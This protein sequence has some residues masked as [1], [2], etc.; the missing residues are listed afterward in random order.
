MSYPPSQEPRLYDS[1][2]P[3]SEAPMPVLG[4]RYADVPLTW[5]DAPP[6]VRSV[7]LLAVLAVI[8]SAF[9]LL[10]GVVMLF[11]SLK[12][13]SE[14]VM[15]LLL[16][17]ASLAFH[18][19]TMGALKNRNALIWQIQRVLSVLGLL[20]IP[21]GTIIHGYILYHWYKPEVKDWFQVS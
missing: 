16:G 18:I 5:R 3:A 6:I 4:M 8:G 14:S 1:G 13:A 15:L 21:I 10:G 2:G 9:L 7:H 19:W 20:S 11:S 17:A 12:D